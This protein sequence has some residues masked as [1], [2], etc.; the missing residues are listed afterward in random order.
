[1]PYGLPRGSLNL[2]K[3]GV[4]LR[5]VRGQ[6]DAANDVD[7]PLLEHLIEKVADGAPA[8]SLAE[9]AD[10]LAEE[11]EGD[12]MQLSTKD[13]GCQRK[14]ASRQYQRAVKANGFALKVP[15]SY[16]VFEEDGVTVSLPYLK[17][18]RMLNYLLTD[19]PWL[20][21]GGL[22]P[23]GEARQLL[24]T[25]WNLYRSEHGSHEVFRMAAEN[26]IRLDQTIPLILHGDS[27][28]TLKKQPLEVLSFRP[29]LGLD[30]EANILKCKCSQTSTYSGARK[31]S[32]M[33]Q[34][35]NNKHSSYLTHFLT[36]A[37]PSKKFKSTPGLLMSMLEA[38]SM[39]LR[40]ACW[41][42]IAIGN[43][44]YHVAILGMAGDFE[45]HA[46]TGLL[47]RSYQ[48]VGHKNFIPCCSECLAGSMQFPFEEVSS[49]LK[50]KD[51]LYRSPPWTELPPFRHIPFTDCNSGEAARFFKKDP[52]HICRLGI[53]RNFIGSTIVL[54]CLEGV[55]DIQG[56]SRAIQER[57]ARA[58]MAFTLWCDT[59]SVS[60]SGVRSFSK[61]KLHMPTMGS[62]PWLGCK[63]S[64]SILLLRWL[65]F[66][67]GLQRVADPASIVFPLIVQATDS[68]LAFQAIHRHGIWLKK[69]CRKGISRSALGF[70]Q[71]YARLAHNTYQRQLQLYAM[72]P[73]IHSMHHFPVELETSGEH[74]A[75]NPAL[76]DCSMSEDFIG[77]VARQSRRV[78]Y[79]NIVHN[80]ILAYKVKARFVIKRFKKQKFKC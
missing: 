74:L 69:S 46:K 70:V 55:F 78:S 79:V 57:L 71:N 27:G 52:F 44:V 22:K 54:L 7:K 21:L 3:F 2:A 26:K 50:W 36:C 34:R 37:F 30:T 72:V 8:V 53:F 10:A 35:L 64:D 63:G 15:T 75:C 49:N 23:G 47:N 66:L 19:E 9:H 33:A 60:T 20:L 67:G 42:G 77:R 13:L 32:P 28:R 58:W 1:M 14:N 68:A 4:G 51:S 17:P 16:H 25:F 29:A 11:M 48:N 41:D 38:M 18:T 59:H 62:F 65:R 76:F 61:E 43:T 45:W 6:N 24:A 39:D 40:V 80:T 12:A 56:A 73:K 5:S 31:S